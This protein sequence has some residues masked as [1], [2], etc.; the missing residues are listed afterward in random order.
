MDLLKAWGAAAGAWLVG[1]ILMLVLFLNVPSVQ[2]MQS[3]GGR[4]LISYLPSLLLIVLM[5]ALA[6]LVHPRPARD[7]PTR[8]V[9]A[10]AAV[11]AV[12]TIAGLISGVSAG[13]TVENAIATLL[14]GVIGT[15]AGWRLVAVVRARRST[16]D[17]PSMFPYGHKA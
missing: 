16:P 7:N 2:L 15:L 9:L 1:G 11:P 12:S 14:I 8:H 5:A 13:T 3:L 4:I 17:G 6:A 10:V